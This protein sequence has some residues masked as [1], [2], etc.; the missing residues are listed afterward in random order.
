MIRN[1]WLENNDSVAYSIYKIYYYR[2]Q[3]RKDTEQRKP[4]SRLYSNW[5]SRDSVQPETKELEK[6]KILEYE[7]RWVRSIREDIKSSL[8]GILIL[9]QWVKICYWKHKNLIEFWPMWPIVTNVN[10]ILCWLRKWSWRGGIAGWRNGRL[11]WE[12]WGGNSTVTANSR[13]IRNIRKT[14]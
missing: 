6:S 5:L 7:K 11:E 13:G 14:F 10:W 2:Q 3:W 4:N 12:K 9:R 8:I 1:C